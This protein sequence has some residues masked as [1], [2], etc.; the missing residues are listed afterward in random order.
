MTKFTLE[1]NLDVDAADRHPDRL[2]RYLR[3][4]ASHIQAGYGNDKIYNLNG[5][6]VGQYDITDE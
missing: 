6:T 4:V 2:A 1:I 5:N 3:D